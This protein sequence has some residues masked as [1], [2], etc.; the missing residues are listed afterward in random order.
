M[1]IQKSLHVDRTPEETRRRLASQLTYRR[2]WEGLNRVD[3][4]DG[5]MEIA[6]NAGMGVAVEVQIEELPSP[7]GEILF[8]SCHGNVAVVGM[9]EFTAIKERLT[10]VTL[11]MDYTAE[12]PLRAFVDLV[13]RA[14][15]RFLNTQL[16]A[17][18]PMLRNGAEAL[19]PGDVYTEASPALAIC[20]R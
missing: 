11:T 15:D 6:F 3:F 4:A 10:E 7:G 16:A 2:N 1:F 18:E 20:L 14:V 19:N 9:I 8:H 13:T 5:K 17:I 12:S